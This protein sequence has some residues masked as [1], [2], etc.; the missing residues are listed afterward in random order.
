MDLDAERLER[1]GQRGRRVGLDDQVGD[2]SVGRQFDAIC[3]RPRGG[4]AL[5]IGL[6]HVESPAEALGKI[7]ALAGDPD[8]ADVWVA[9]EQVAAAGLRRPAPVASRPGR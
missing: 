7:F 6:R 9:G 5:D 2:L 8:V 4:T 3:V 1:P